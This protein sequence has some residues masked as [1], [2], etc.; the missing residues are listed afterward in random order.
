MTLKTFKKAMVDQK[1]HLKLDFRRHFFVGQLFR[2]ITRLLTRLYWI[3]KSAP[4]M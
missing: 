1:W 3:L 4:V 2:N